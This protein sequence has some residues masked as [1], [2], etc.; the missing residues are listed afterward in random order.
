MGQF[1]LLSFLVSMIKGRKLFLD[2]AI[3]LVEGRQLVQGKM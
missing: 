2:H 3:P 1:R